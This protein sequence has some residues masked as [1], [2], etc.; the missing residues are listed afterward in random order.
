MSEKKEVTIDSPT[1]TEESKGGKNTPGVVDYLQSPRKKRK[2][3]IVIATGP[4]VDSE[5]KQAMV[6][7]AK[8]QYP[9]FAVSTPQTKEEF[10]RQFTR[11]IVLAIVSDD[12]T[13]TETLPLVKRMKQEKHESAVPVLFLTNSP[14][15]L[16]KS[17]S[18][19]LA[20]WQEVDEYVITNLTPRQ[21]LFAKIKSGVDER[22]R[23]RS[24]R[25]KVSFPA[26][27]TVLNQGDRKFSGTILDLSIHGAL[28]RVN[29]DYTFNKNDQI[30][31]HIPLGKFVKSTGTDILR[32]GG[33]IKRIFI[34]G[35]TAGIAW[36]NLSEYKIASL[37][38]LLTSI[39]DQ[40]IVR[41]ASA[42]RARIIKAD[43][44]A[45]IATNRDI[46]P[47]SSE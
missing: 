34:A 15:S 37:T 19:L 29:D 13:G 21:Y 16:I 8:Q 47:S 36:D 25:Y 46:V 14:D 39:I 18:E 5:T 35:D 23:R 9:K 1:K 22:Y 43:A 24:R 12:F 33:R 10:V 38:S 26:A 4:A 3:F 20:P 11:N 31:I 2:N 28:L 32:V 7:F 40:T 27:F 30:M 17:Y 42:T 45:L 6:R 41:Q 44:D